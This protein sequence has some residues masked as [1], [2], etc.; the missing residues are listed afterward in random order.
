M[1]SYKQVPVEHM[2]GAVQRYLEHGISPGSFLTSVITNNLSGAVAHG[3]E[4]NIRHLA[5]WV[6]F[7]YNHTPSNSWGSVETME[8]YM[9]SKSVRH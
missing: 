5:D 2:V 7:F 6:K 9:K 4:D 8:D 3:D 1:Q